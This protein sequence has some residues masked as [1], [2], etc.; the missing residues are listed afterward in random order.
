MPGAQTADETVTADDNA[1]GKLFEGEYTVTYHP[2]TG[3]AVTNVPAPETTG[4]GDYTVNNTKTPQRDGYQ[5]VGWT[6]NPGD[7]V[8]VDTVTV[9][10][11]VTL[12]AKWVTKGIGYE[13]T[14][15]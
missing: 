12:F 11:N 15:D 5:F 10:S 9:A 2:G 8:V 3:A 1:N 14:S 13:F 4:L 7:G 6:L